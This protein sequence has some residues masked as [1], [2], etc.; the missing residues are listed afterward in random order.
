MN[1]RIARRLVVDPEARLSATERAALDTHV[2]ACG[3]CARLQRRETVLSQ[4]LEDLP[5]AEPSANFEWRLRLRLSQL[6]RQVP[7]AADVEVPAG[8]RRWVLPFAL[9]TAAAAAVVVAVG[10]GI[11]MRHPAPPQGPVATTES[12]TTQPDLAP[13][14]PHPQGAGG[15]TWPRLVPVRAGAPLGP[16]VRADAT[17]SI[18]GEARADTSQR[19]TRRAEPIEVQPVGW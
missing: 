5:M 3:A 9:S 1:C 16:E 10:L 2:R 8:H 18:L 19:P 6:E 15:V 12:R 4:W 7:S 14:A 13:W 11:G 17:P